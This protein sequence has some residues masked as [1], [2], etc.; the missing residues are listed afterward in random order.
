MHR[1]MRRTI[2]VTVTDVLTLVWA[3]SPAGLP[4]LPDD[5]SSQGEAGYTHRVELVSVSSSVAVVVR[6]HVTQVEE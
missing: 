3:E 5:G 2:L 1:M 4:G 6:A